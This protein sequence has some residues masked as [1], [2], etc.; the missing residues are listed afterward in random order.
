FLVSATLQNGSVTQV[1]IR[2]ESGGEIVLEDPFKGVEFSCDKAF[3]KQGEN[4]VFKL[5]KGESVNLNK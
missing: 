4:L 2:S 3:T 1:A 5:G